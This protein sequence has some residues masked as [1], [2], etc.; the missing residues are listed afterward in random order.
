VRVTAARVSAL[1]LI[2]AR[3]ASAQDSSSR[4]GGFLA[5]VAVGSARIS[6]TRAERAVSGTLAFQPRG[7]LTLSV[8]PT[9]V[10]ATN[11]TAGGTLTSTGLGDLPIAIG[12]E[13]ELAGPLSTEFSASLALTLPTGSTQCGL[14]SGATSVGL[15]V[16]AGV[17]PAEPLHLSIGASRGLSGLSSQSTLDAPRA[18]SLS[19]DAGFDVAERWSASLSLSGDFGTAD[20]TQPLSRDLGFGASHQLGKRLAVALEASHGLTS[21]SPKWAF[22]F[23]IGTAYSGVSA[24]GANAPF[25]RLKRTF[26]GGVSRGQGRGKIGGG[27]TGGGSTTTT[28]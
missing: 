8:S 24:V 6:S 15:D 7:W 10:R 1:L 11:D 23:S 3:A 16:G 9:L 5:G 25:R 18:T 21:G 13:R 20:S 14:G 28:C 2:I 19:F 12:V 17:S 4:G 27:K 26:V 22:S